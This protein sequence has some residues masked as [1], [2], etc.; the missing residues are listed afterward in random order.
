MVGADV[1][2]L[3]LRAILL[4]C[5]H[6]SGFRSVALAHRRGLCEADPHEFV[7]RGLLC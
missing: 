6:L 7:G 1:L 5:D 3:P 4:T 2:R